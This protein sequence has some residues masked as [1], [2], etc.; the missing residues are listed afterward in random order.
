MVYRAEHHRRRVVACAVVGRKQQQGP[1]LHTPL[2][3]R[4]RSLPEIHPQRI[5]LVAVVHTR[6]LDIASWPRRKSREEW[7]SPWAEP[8]ADAAVS[9][10]GCGDRNG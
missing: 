8:A 4:E 1:P 6:V 10:L 3:L 2:P 7:G 5:A 9:V